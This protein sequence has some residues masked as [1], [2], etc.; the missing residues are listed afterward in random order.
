MG[1]NNAPG[2]SVPLFEK[3]SNDAP[4]INVNGISPGLYPSLTKENCDSLCNIILD[5]PRTS[6]ES[7]LTKINTP[8]DIQLFNSPLKTTGIA[9]G[10][11]MQSRKPKMSA[12][13]AINQKILM[14]S[15]K[16]EECMEPGSTFS[17]IDA[18][19]LKPF[20]SK[21]YSDP[22]V[23]EQLFDCNDAEAFSCYEEAPTKD[24]SEPAPPSGSL[25]VPSK[26]NCDG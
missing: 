16:M 1:V 20:T 10:G 11:T 24:L 5:R 25:S 6:A 9:V 18:G 8:R 4:F 22:K 15:C 14:D 12:R 21:S 13:K 17:A 3:L 7:W 23:L 26:R 19:K 2:I